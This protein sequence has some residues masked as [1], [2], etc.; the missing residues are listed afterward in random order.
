M[1][2]QRIM[3]QFDQISNSRAEETKEPSCYNLVLDNAGKHPTCINKMANSSRRTHNGCN[4]SSV[5]A[6][7]RCARGCK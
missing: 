6:I 5:R 4:R 1:E 3:N 7:H 2:E